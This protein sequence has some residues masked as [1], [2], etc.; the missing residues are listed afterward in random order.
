MCSLPCIPLQDEGQ[1]R[2]AEVGVVA[3]LLEVAAVLPLGPHRHLDEAH[4][5]EEGHRQTLGHHGE[6]KP[7]AQLQRGD[8]RREGHCTH[9]GLTH[10]H[11]QDYF[12]NA[13][14]NRLLVT[15]LY[16]W[17]II[18]KIDLKKYMYFT[19]KITLSP[20]KHI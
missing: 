6:A 4:Y 19:S 11:W 13:I 14:Y 18:S 12:H 15:R 17:I 2:R 20:S 5:G 10:T 1:D 3:E 9:A 8:N 16:D 7:G